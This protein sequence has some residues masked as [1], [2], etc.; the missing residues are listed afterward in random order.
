MSYC[1]R[2]RTGIWP[3]FG[4]SVRHCYDS[5]G[6][7]IRPKPVQVGRQASASLTAVRP[8][9]LRLHRGRCHYP[10]ENLVSLPCVR[11]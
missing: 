1:I 5:F 2:Q 9:F 7:T 4:H 8:R 6:S 3:E 10:R 11:G